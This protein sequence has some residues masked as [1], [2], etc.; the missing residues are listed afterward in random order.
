MLTVQIFVLIKQLNSGEVIHVTD[1][2]KFIIKKNNNNRKYDYF[3]AGN[4]TLF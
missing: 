4:I 3:K 1:N 2:V